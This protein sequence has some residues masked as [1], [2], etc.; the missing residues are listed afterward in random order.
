MSDKKFV[1]G[2]VVNKKTVTW[3]G[4]SFD[5]IRVGF[6]VDEMIEWLQANRDEKGW[7]NCNIKTSKAGKPYAEED[8]Y[9]KEDPLE[10]AREAFYGDGQHVD[11]TTI[12][13]IPF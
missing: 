4:G 2:M 6:K 12:E 3:D 5:Y 1:N 10:P 7:A 9:K 11:N 8:T 13:E